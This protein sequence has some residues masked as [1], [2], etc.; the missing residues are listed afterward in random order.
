MRKSIGIAALAIGAAVMIGSTHAQAPRR[1]APVLPPSVSKRGTR[2]IDA[3]ALNILGLRV[4]F[5][6]GA[7]GP[8]SFSEAAAK[9]DM[10]GTGFREA[11]KL[12]EG[13]SR[14]SQES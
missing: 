8:I 9:A 14:D 4:G 11:S 3:Q 1:S 6:A 12:P 5:S 13:Q 7:F 10:L 2:Q